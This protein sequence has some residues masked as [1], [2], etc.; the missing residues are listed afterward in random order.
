MPFI[1]LYVFFNYFVNF[2]KSFYRIV[3]T[4]KI[5]MLIQF[6]INLT[7]FSE[8]LVYLLVFHLLVFV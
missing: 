6:W 3:R 4:I 2:L 5:L 7:C 8:F 1:H